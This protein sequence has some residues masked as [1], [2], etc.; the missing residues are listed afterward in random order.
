MYPQ[1]CEQCTMTNPKD[2]HDDD[3]DVRLIVLASV[4]AWPSFHEHQHNIQVASPLSQLPFKMMMMIK[5]PHP[6]NHRNH[7]HDHHP[8]IHR[9]H[10]HGHQHHNH[11]NHHHGDQHCDDDDHPL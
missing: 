11:R 6:H 10:H 5:N 2:A 8:H 3:D 4:E 1:N 7:R 9:N